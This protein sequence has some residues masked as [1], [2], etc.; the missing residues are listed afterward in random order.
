MTQR[1]IYWRQGETLDITVPTELDLTGMDLALR[2]RRR[3]SDDDIMID[4]DSDGPTEA[5]ITAVEGGYRVQ[6]GAAEG[7]LIQTLGRD[8]RWVYAAKAINSADPEIASWMD[9]GD[10]V[11]KADP[12]RAGDQVAPT[13]AGDLRYLQPSQIVAGTNVTITTAGTGAGLTLTFSATGGGG[14]VAWTDVSGKPTFATVAT[15]GAYSDLSGRPTLG[16][17]AAL[18]VGTGAGTVAA[19]NDAR[20]SDSRTPTTHTH[21]LADLTQSSATTRQVAE[22]SGSAWGPAT[23]A[24]YI[25]NT[26]ARSAQIP[27]G[28]AAG[29][30]NRGPN[31]ADLQSWRTLATQ[32]ASGTGGAIGGGRNN[33]ASGGESVVAGGGSNTASGERAT[34][35]GGQN[36]TA[37]GSNA[38]V[39]G[40]QFNVASGE[41]GWIPGGS[42]GSNLGISGAHAWASAGRGGGFGDN[43]HFGG[44]LGITTTDAT[45]TV[46]TANRAAPSTTAGVV[47]VHVMPNNSMWLGYIKIGARSTAGN[48]F[49]WHYEVHAKRGANAAATSVVDANL[50]RSVDGGLTGA[51]VAIAANTTRGSIEVTGT[52]LAATEIDWTCEFF[53]IMNYR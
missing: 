17:A 10:W 48:T 50:A 6:L 28:T 38:A 16:T 39:S 18:D 4:L 19:G 20:L 23:P 45:P 12:A 27:D 9:Y 35:S 46:I 5:R 41:N 26:S 25:V 22:W 21:P 34:V 47:N 30:G 7:S 52:G 33:T 24:L 31:S 13:P 11:V 42:V 43:Q 44:V 36:N 53:G 2:V 8:A 3:L 49:S 32:I 14:S 37:S 40:G 1:D 29:G 51:S 15:S